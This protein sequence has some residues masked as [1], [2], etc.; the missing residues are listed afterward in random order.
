[1]GPAIQDETADE[2]CDSAAAI[3]R[4]L[5][6]WLRDAPHCP[7]ISAGRQREDR[8]AAVLDLLGQPGGQFR[9]GAGA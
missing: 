5:F 4:A 6:A 1:M 7:D 2:A 3:R 8:P 9:L